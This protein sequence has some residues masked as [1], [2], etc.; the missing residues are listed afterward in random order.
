MLEGVGYLCTAANAMRKR[1]WRESWLKGRRFPWL[2]KEHIVYEDYQ[3]CDLDTFQER[4]V[5]AGDF[6]TMLEDGFPRLGPDGELLEEE[7]DQTAK[8]TL[9]PKVAQQL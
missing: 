5:M 8:F 4:A 3:N 9:T 6:D 7:F 2:K 1:I